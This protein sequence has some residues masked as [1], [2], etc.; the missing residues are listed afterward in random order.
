VRS[1]GYTIFIYYLQNPKS[2]VEWLIHRAIIS[3]LREAD[4]KGGTRLPDALNLNPGVIKL[5]VALDQ[6]ET[7]SRAFT[8]M[9]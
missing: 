9:H 4:G 5:D 2:T 1:G 3:L 8:A 6:R 7:E